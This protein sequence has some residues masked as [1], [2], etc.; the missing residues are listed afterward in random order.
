LRETVSAGGQTGIT[1]CRAVPRTCLAVDMAAAQ[2]R[3]QGLRGRQT[4]GFA[5]RATVRPC[6]TIARK[7]STT[8]PIPPW[9]PLP[10]TH[11]RAGADCGLRQQH[12]ASRHVPERR[13]RRQ[14]L[15]TSIPR[16]IQ[17]EP[18]IGAHACDA[19][20]PSAAAAISPSVVRRRAPCGSSSR[21]FFSGS[22]RQGA[23]T[24]P[25]SSGRQNSGTSQS[26][27]VIDHPKARDQTY[28]SI[29]HGCCLGIIGQLADRL[30]QPR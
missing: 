26:A 6:R 17:R 20:R 2:F 13:T 30:D 25:S 10:A 23:A 15:G 18:A 12:P 3:S 11:V 28:P 24:V 5:S 22:F 19:K 4:R 1:P 21:V 27:I 16:R 29:W 8:V 7:S 14:T 9:C